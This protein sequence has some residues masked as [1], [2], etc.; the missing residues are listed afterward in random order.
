MDIKAIKTKLDSLN[1]QS[2]GG[3]D[4]NLFWKPTPGKEV[5]RVV[6]SKFNPKM[7]FKE[8]KFYYGIGSKK[9]MASPLNWGDKDPIFEFAKSL[10]NSNDKENWRLAKKLDAKV[11]TF[12]PIIIRGE[13]D[14]GV[15]LWQFGKEIYEAFLTM[16]VD[17][18]IGDYTDIVNGRDIKL[19]TVGPEITGTTYNKTTISPSL[20]MSPLSAK[21]EEVE[22]FLE[23]Q[24]DPLSVFKAYSFDEMKAS[25]EEWLQ[26][27]EDDDS[28]LVTET[29]PPTNY[30]LKKKSSDSEKFNSLFKGNDVEGTPEDDLPF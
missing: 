2:T 22:K 11:R 9:V 10:R 6:P 30:N 15:K 19:N 18:E 24:T 23:E 25:L 8:M 26:P 28:E 7:P 16:A 12:V 21:K 29:A 1:N 14:K 3:Y 20:K 27:D 13:E 5:I 4:K 17:D